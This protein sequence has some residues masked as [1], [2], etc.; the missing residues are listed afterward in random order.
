MIK[1]NDLA[2]LPKRWLIAN[3]YAMGKGQA[4]WVSDNRDD[5]LYVSSSADGVELI[6]VTSSFFHTPE[7]IPTGS[8]R[9][10]IMQRYPSAE[11]SEDFLDDV[12][13]G[14]AFEFAKGGIA[15]GS[16]CIAI[17]VHAPG[18]KHARLE[19]AEEIADFIDSNPD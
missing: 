3:D 1:E 12:A 5:T 14:I 4:V 9:D 13:Q 16:R 19:G 18:D 7:G 6:R 11:D 15:A 17:M 8:G 2:K 10:E